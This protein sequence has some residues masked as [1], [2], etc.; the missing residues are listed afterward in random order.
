[1]KKLIKLKGNG[2]IH[3]TL[4]AY[5]CGGNCSCS[6]HPLKKDDAQSEVDSRDKPEKVG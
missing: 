5:S 4:E 6:C 1:M 2:I 3:A